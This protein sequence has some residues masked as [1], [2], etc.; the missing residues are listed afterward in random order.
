MLIKFMPTVFCPWCVQQGG[1]RI[2]LEFHAYPLSTIRLAGGQIKFAAMLTPVLAC[3]ACEREVRGRL[4]GNEAVFP[5]P[6]VRADG[7]TGQPSHG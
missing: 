6:H 5:D 7:E 1:L 4:D 2:R 3:G